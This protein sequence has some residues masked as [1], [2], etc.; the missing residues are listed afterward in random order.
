[1]CCLLFLL[2]GGLVDL[3]LLWGLWVRQEQTCGLLL[4]GGLVD[5]LLLRGLWAWRGR[6][7]GLWGRQVQAGL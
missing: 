2:R 5:L 1:M 7:R 4:R 3:L 6:T